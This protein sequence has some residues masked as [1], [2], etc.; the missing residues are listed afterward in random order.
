[1]NMPRVTIVV[2][3]RNRPADLLGCVQSLQHLDYPDF[4][5]LIVDQ[6]P[7]DVCEIAVK[8]LDDTRLKLIRTTTV[9]RS[10]GANLGAFYASGSIIAFTDD[11]ITVPAGWLKRI[12]AIFRKEQDVGVYYGAVAAAPHDRS[13]FLIPEY[14]PAAYQV[15]RGR[16][17]H[18]AVIGMGANMA[19]RRDVFRDIG[20][21]DA[22]MG[23]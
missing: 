16:L 18:A 3:T 23:V 22:L 19:V 9:G 8:K 12:T 21:F 4:E 6:S 2:P 7:N 20:G 5:V 15:T 17:V 1:M 14:L 13:E 10:R 11:D